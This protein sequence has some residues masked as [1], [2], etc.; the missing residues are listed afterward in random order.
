MPTQKCQENVAAMPTPWNRYCTPNYC[1]EASFFLNIHCTTNHLNPDTPIICQDPAL[2]SKTDP[3]YCYC[4]CSCFAYDTPIKVA[5][6]AYALSQDVKTGTFLLAAGTSLDWK[7]TQVTYGEGYEAPDPHPMYYVRYEYPEDKETFREVIVTAD[8]LFLMADDK[9]ATVQDIRPGDKLRRADGKTAAVLFSARGTYVGGIQTI[10]LGTYDGGSLD[11]H[12]INTNGIVTSDYSVQVFYVGAPK[13]QRDKVAA[14][15]TKRADG[16][17]IG[18]PDFHARYPSPAF[19][20]FLADKKQWPGGFAPAPMEGIINVPPTAFRFLTELQEEDVYNN[21]EFYARSTTTPLGTALFLVEW[22]KAFYPDVIFL[23]DWANDRPNA[24]AWGADRQ[25]LAVITGGLLRAKVLNRDGFALIMSMLIVRLQGQYACK[26]E[27]G[28]MAVANVL[29]MLWQAGLYLYFVQPAV[30]EV[31]A[32]YN[33]CKANGGGNPDDVCND[34]SLDCLIECYE[35]GIM[36]RPL[37]ACAKPKP[38]YFTADRAQAASSSR[39]VVMFNDPVDPPS[40]SIVTNY[41]F[42][43]EVP[44]SAAAVD[45]LDPKRV[46]IEV[47]K[48]Q[49]A[50]TYTLAVAHVQSVAAKTVSPDPTILVFTSP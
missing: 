8:H 22:F 13:A 28:Q 4:C 1:S 50:R 5:D 2:K 31:K 41:T 37:P 24:Y 44:V 14:A 17:E 40:G 18:T 38:R 47:D 19:E 25:K 39:V 3:G 48:L 16:L 9:L 43:P 29:R 6:D 42:D 34:P 10:E 7:R 11:G 26:G 20:A 45:K 27:I 30:D 36:F 32:L 33:L 23:I 46:E 49:P 35:S 12:L 15:V 21:G